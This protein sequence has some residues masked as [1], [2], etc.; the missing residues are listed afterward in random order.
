[1]TIIPSLVPTALLSLAAALLVPGI[2]QAQVRVLFVGGQADA[3][4][5]ADPGVWEF[6]QNRFGAANVSYEQSAQA[7]TADAENV[8]V[9]VLSSTPGSGSIRTKFRNV[10]V[11]V[12][13]WE[14]ALSEVARV[15]NFAF[16]D[17]GRTKSNLTGWN[18]TDNS[19]YIT[20][21]LPLGDVE[22][23]D[24]AAET[25]QLDGELA[26]TVTVLATITD[27]EVPTLSVAEA[28]TKQLGDVVAVGRRV[29][30]PM[31]DSTANAFTDLG[32]D[33]FGRAVEWAAGADVAGGQI[34]D[35]NEDPGDSL[36]II[37]NAAATTEWRPTGGV[38]DSG[39]MALADNEDSARAA[40]IFPIVEDPI[41]SFK[42]SVAAR[43]GGGE[44]NPAD[45][46]SISIVRPEDPLLH[47]DSRGED[48]AGGFPELRGLQEEGSTTG[49]AIGFDTYVN[50][51][52]AGD[53][54]A[55]IVGISVRV[56]GALVKQIPAGTKNGA[57]DDVTSLQTGPLSQ[58]DDPFEN[59]TWQPF[60]V[61]LTEDSKLNIRWK[62]QSVLEN[63]AVDW[64][65]SENMQ[66]IFG[67]RTGGSNE[68]HHFDDLTLEIV[69][70]TVARISRVTRGRDGVTYTYSNSEESQLDVESI[71]LTIDGVEVTPTIEA[72]A[73]GA[74]VSY[75]TSDEPWGFGSVHPWTLEAMD[76]NG[77]DIGASGEIKIATPV[78]PVGR[79]LPGPEGVVGAFSTRYVWDTGVTIDSLGK[80]LE[81][82]LAADDPGFAGE[83]I[84]ETHEVIDHGSG[85]FFSNNFPYPDDFLGES[86][87]IQASKGN[88]LIT[89]AG[90][91]T[92]GVRTD[93][94]FGVRIHGMTFSEV[95]GAG[96]IDGL[97]PD[98]FFFTGPTSNSQTRAIARDVQPGVYPIEFLW[99]ERG[100]GDYGELFAARGAFPNEGD[101]D[102]WE[103]VGEGLALVAGV[104]QP[105]V[106][107]R[108]AVTDAVD[109]AFT[110]PSAESEHL[111][112]MST[113]LAPGEWQVV[114]DAVLSMGN[115][116]FTFTTSRPE[117]AATYYRVAMLPP[118]PL[119]RE[120]F[121]SGAEG[122]ITSTNSAD[123]QW[124]LGAPDIEGLTEAHGGQNVYGTN[125]DGPVI[126]GE[127]V[128]SA[129]LRSPVIDLTGVDRPKLK[130]WYHVDTT[131]DAEGVQLKIL[132]EDG[133]ELYVHT[134]IFWGLTEGW[135]E[136]RLTIPERAREQK[137]IVEWLLLAAVGG[138]AGFYLDD[139][140][141]D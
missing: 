107:T 80:A 47:P 89:E 121:E 63:F 7:G 94:G 86:D 1:M 132:D 130:F 33:L 68:A 24:P 54:E 72:T 49:L 115:G 51:V 55:D 135:T 39:Y 116:L 35:F 43:I 30:F 81:L 128:T 13:N 52:L 111:L 27:G 133:S 58:T 103:L 21:G 84:D 20:Q 34:F 18:I 45:G 71:K 62:G 23:W 110:T 46:F 141:L 106:I 104:S 91:Y 2:I 112:E 102:T 92:F 15:G 75:S 64:F 9:V 53:T 32:W 31:T 44:A 61:E 70:T 10:P 26:E 139:V 123:T 120:D 56:D 97:V 79:P 69:S 76:Q 3:A 87:F 85:G 114:S 88:I 29:Q 4:Q 138:R 82:I 42:I 131:E 14:E 99:F 90:D 101:T 98:A 108:V 41:S 48:W 65:P 127:G 119:F 50:G 129:S 17:G 83:V 122:W 60:E 5:A 59:L 77:L 137:V 8:D 118:P 93:D 109:I 25:W 78:F 22:I 37:S 125:L 95:S 36:E 40:L 6:L 38:N 57:P 73:D 136:F 74:T 100:G 16:N 67:A 113:T 134:E 117:S 124:E 66:V 140:E 11:G 96:R 105:P 126:V 19:H 28:G 12:L